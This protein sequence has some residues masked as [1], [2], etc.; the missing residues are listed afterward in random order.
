MANG[1]P[2]VN[3]MLSRPI[4]VGIMVLIVLALFAPVISKV[5]AK[6]YQAKFGDVGESAEDV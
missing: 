5:I 4:S 3:Y 2:L 1:V 6:K